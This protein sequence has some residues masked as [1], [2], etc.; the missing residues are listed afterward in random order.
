MLDKE[1]EKRLGY[2]SGLSE[3]KSH[4]WCKKIQWDKLTA[5]AI[6][7]PIIPNI[8]VSNFDPEYTSM[9]VD[10]TAFENPDTCTD[11]IYGDFDY[12]RPEGL[13][14]HKAANEFHGK[15]ESR[16]GRSTTASSTGSTQQT[17]IIK[18]LKP[19]DTSQNSLPE[20]DP[21]PTGAKS[22]RFV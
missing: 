17:S 11:K 14:S 9:P 12:I 8:K 19:E 15:S 21:I 6:P 18:R 3:V 4:P 2:K 7:P 1:P 10:I 16:G 5:K 22:A 13:I 20:I